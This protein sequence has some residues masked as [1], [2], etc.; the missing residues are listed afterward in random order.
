MSKAVSSPSSNNPPQKRNGKQKPDEV[1]L[2]EILSDPQRTQAVTHLIREKLHIGPL[3]DP[4]TLREYDQILDNGA[5]RIMAMAEKQS[6][7]RIEIEKIVILSREEQGR[8]GQ[9]FAFVL[10]LFF[11]IIG[12]ILALLNHTEVAIAAFGLPIATIV[13]AFIKG[14]SKQN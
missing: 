4:D 3:P 5:E 14:K 7:H 6:S 11:G 2:E 9:S 8:K 13:T 12:F 10:A 1:I